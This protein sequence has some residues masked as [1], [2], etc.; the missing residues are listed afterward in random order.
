MEAFVIKLQEIH[1]NRVTYQPGL[2]LY[3]TVTE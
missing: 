3:F 1:H 2:A